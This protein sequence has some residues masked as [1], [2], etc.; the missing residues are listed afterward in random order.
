MK[1]NICV[2]SCSALSIKR[3]DGPWHPCFKIITIHMHIQINSI[4][5]RVFITNTEQRREVAEIRQ[6]DDEERMCV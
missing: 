5:A 2:K 3:H 6:K 4:A 1:A